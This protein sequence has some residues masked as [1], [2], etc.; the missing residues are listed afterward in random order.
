[1]AYESIK[2]IYLLRIGNIL[3]E[4]RGDLVMPLDYE[5]DVSNM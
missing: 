1:M 3:G 2:I 4:G 5:A